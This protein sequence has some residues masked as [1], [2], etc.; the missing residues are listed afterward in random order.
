MAKEIKNMGAS[1]RTR[2]LNVSKERGQDY[3]LVLTR[4]ANER[5]LYRLAESVHADR[6]VLKDAVLLMTWFG[7]PFR[8]TRDVD[9]LGNGDP[10]PAVVL[11]V[12]QD[13]LAREGDDGVRF[14]AKGAEIGRIREETEYGG[15]RIKTTADV[16]GARVPIRID[17]G[18][19]D[20][21][22]PQPEELTLPGLLDMPPAKLR[23]YA[24][25][26][27]IAEK[28]QAMVALGLT[29]ARIKDYYDV[30]LLSQLFEF[31]EGQLARAIA[32]TFER[33]GTDVPSGTPDG[34]TPAFGEDEAKQRQWEAFIRDVSFGPGSEPVDGPRR[35]RQGSGRRRERDAGSPRSRLPCVFP[36]RSRDG[37]GTVR[38]RQGQPETRHRTRRKAGAGLL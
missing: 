38:W 23:G 12:F 19:G 22:E 10:D 14:D 7:E 2:L 21:T 11:D 36:P 3:Q 16:V 24:R 1:V 28:F 25:E 31:D 27:V 9:L 34:L 13:I 32:A 37:G 29:N 33:R 6:F 5:L 17:V 26:T 4:Y 15:L 8:G 18:F 35:R 30:W 20:A